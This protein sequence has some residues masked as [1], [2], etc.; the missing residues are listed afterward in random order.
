VSGILVGFG[1]FVY[2]SIATA[3]LY[4]AADEIEERTRL[5]EEYQEELR[6]RHPTMSKEDEWVM[7]YYS[8][9]YYNRNRELNYEIMFWKQQADLADN[10]MLG[11]MGIFAL[12]FLYGGAVL[13]WD[14]FLFLMWY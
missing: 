11:G 12:P 8:R 2:G 13:L 7:K 5:F 10:I 1:G 14:E 9:E 6:L 3:K 4:A